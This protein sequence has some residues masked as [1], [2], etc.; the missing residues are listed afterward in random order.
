MPWLERSTMSSK[1]EFINEMLNK[2]I[3]IK[4]L[5]IKFNISEKTAHKWKKRFLEYGLI[6][7][8]DISRKPTNSP[9]KLDE[10]TVIQLI[11]LRTAHPSW[12]PKKIQVLFTKANP[13]KEMPSISSIFRVIDK[14]KLVKK[15]RRKS[16]KTDKDNVLRNLIQPNTINDVWT[17]DFKGYWFSDG[18]KCLPLTIRD[19]KSKFILDITLCPNGTFETVKCVFEKVFKKYGLPKVIRSDNGSPFAN[20]N[21]PIGLSRLSAWFI[22]LDIIPDRITPGKP[23]QNGSHERMHRDLSQD[24]QK[25][26]SGGVRAN[27]IAIDNWINEYNNIRPHEALNMQTP[28]E[29]YSKSLRK[30]IK[31]DEIEYPIGVI[32]RKVMGN[33]TINLEGVIYR[34]TRAL[35]GHQIGLQET[36]VSNEY[37]VWLNNYPLFILDTSLN[38]IKIEKNVIL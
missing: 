13:D 4:D 3:P 31:Y 23:G 29:I 14:A 12:G 28:S 22:S 38:K 8:E 5:A 35:S 24:I 18:E 32:S 9:Q 2:E 19:L 17:I 21:S 15:R 34:L 10:D 27:Q 25:R 20:H 36:E 1:K 30:Y 7:L 11:N 26:I 6:G 16:V 33:G 37:K